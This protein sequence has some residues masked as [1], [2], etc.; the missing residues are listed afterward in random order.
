FTANSGVWSYTEQEKIP[1]NG[2]KAKAFTADVYGSL[3]VAY[4][5]G[6]MYRFTEKELLSTSATG[7]RVADNLTNTKKI[8]VDYDENLYALSEGTLTKY[9]Q[10]AQ[11][12]YEVN[13]IYTPNY[14]LVKDDNPVLTSFTF[15][16]K[17]QDAYFLY[18]NDYVVKSDELQIPQVNPIPVVNAVDCIFGAGNRDYSMVTIDED[19]ILTEFDITALQNATEFPY[20]AFERRYTPFTALKIGE[21][22]GHAIIAVE[23]GNVGYKT[24]LVETQHCTTLNADTYRTAYTETDKTG[25]LTNAVRLYKFPYLNNLLTVAEMPRGA[26]VTLLGELRLPDRTYYE[27][28]YTDT[29]GVVQTGYVPTSY[30]N[31]FDGTAPTSQTITYGA[32]EDDT[33]SVGR[34][35]YILLGFGAIGILIDVLLL[36]KSKETDDN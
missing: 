11:G 14:G 20:I 31:L 28:T 15:G 21:E 23:N 8:A 30:V 25:Y 6:E 18:E 9:I 26:Q 33:D 3:Y 36:K 27:I 32:T 4:D 7:L 17:N 24:Y 19:A 1:L 2:M 5:S 34:M 12:M 35:V 10:N 29:N 22:E 13:A 16:V